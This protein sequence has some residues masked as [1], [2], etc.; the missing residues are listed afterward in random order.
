MIIWGGLRKKAKPVPGGRVIERKCPSCG[1]TAAFHQVRVERK[2]NLFSV[3]EVWNDEYDAYACSSCS[4][5]AE[6]EDTKAP[7]LSEPERA[8]LEQERRKQ[9]EA[10]KRDTDRAVDAELAAL[11][12]KLGK[13]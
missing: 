11:R 10:A 3:L 13:K 2:V 4:E 6:L 8:K 9:L 5:V 1:K 7:E 12:A